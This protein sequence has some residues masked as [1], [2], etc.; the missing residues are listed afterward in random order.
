MSD[1][2]PSPFSTPKRKRDDSAL[3]RPLAP[4][5]TEFCFDANVN[6]STGL[7]SQANGSS[8]PRTKVVHRFRGLALA[9][10]TVP[11][12]ANAA[13]GN[14]SGNGSGGGV[15][16]APQL[17]QGHSAA[18]DNVTGAGS[19]TDD[20]MQVDED[21]STSRKRSRVTVT[22]PSDGNLAQVRLP[23][24]SAISQTPNNGG[25]QL[26]LPSS[27]TLTDF[28][29]APSHDVAPTASKP[30]EAYALDH[31]LFTSSPKP[32]PARLP[33]PSSAH[34]QQAE[35]AKTKPRRR[36]GTPPR[37]DTH[38]KTNASQADSD[39]PIID[40]FDPVRANLTW[41]EDEIT[42]YDP[43]DE[44]D[45]GVGINGIG[46]KP[47]PAIAYARTM[48]RKQQLAD[49]RKREEREARARRSHR[50]RGTPEKLD[51]SKMSQQD[52]GSRKVRFTEAESNMMVG[53]V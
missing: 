34:G 24:L 26:G 47:T 35:P 8:S 7:V 14:G 38:S 20:S 51:V 46:F 40:A 36:M 22:S 13:S 11:S 15:P 49:Y 53:I 17:A 9:D 50:R 16:A 44:D 37:T 39:T 43:E 29:F 52:S 30:L 6:V 33:R 28:Q 5:N 27:V 4:L 1:S 10:R 3:Q 45:D 25:R 32:S 42:V 41:H 48:K 23:S 2:A 21:D 19:T 31:R 18:A 12:N